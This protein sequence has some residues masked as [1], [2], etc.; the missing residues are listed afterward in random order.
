[1]LGLSVFFASPG[2]VKHGFWKHF[3]ER[4]DVCEVGEPEDRDRALRMAIISLCMERATWA[5]WPQ[6]VDSKG[7]KALSSG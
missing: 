2:N 6:P 4:G 5:L 3:A 7:V 1:M